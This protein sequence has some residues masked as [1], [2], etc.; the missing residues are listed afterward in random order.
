M[1]IHDAERVKHQIVLLKKKLIP[2]SAIIAIKGIK[3][4]RAVDD[5]PI[6]C[7]FFQNQFYRL[8]SGLNST[9]S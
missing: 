6:T 8:N 5:L 3:V 9:T 7:S 1:V 4:L 2:N